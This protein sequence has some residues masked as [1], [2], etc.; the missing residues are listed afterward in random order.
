MT[1][2]TYIGTELELFA[3][4]HHWKSYIVSLL[5]QYLQGDLLEVGAGMGSNTKLL[6]NSLYNSWLCLEPDLKLFQ[7]LENM[8]KSNKIKKCTAQQG[9]I[10]NLQSE[11]LFD[12][13]LYLDV[14]EHIEADRKELLNASQHLK[15]DGKLIILAPAHQYLFT[16]FDTA[17]GHYRRYD[18][19][20]LKAI[21]PEDIEV[22]KLIYLDCVGLFASLVNKLFLQQSQPTLKQL[23]LWDQLMVPFSKKID[24]AIGY[25]FGKSILLVGQK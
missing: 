4:A 3:Q 12:A 20:T 22:I 8:I 24:P 11:Q 16:P 7:A 6:T 5:N 17:I 9:T 10:E 14:L 21:V 25:S 18:K 23:K 2:L 1:Q 15:K 19:P 13:I